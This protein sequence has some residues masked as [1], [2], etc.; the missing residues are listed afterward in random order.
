M[1]QCTLGTP[2]FMPPEACRGDPFSARG[3][4]LWACGV[5]L[6]TL[7]CGRVPFQGKTVFATYNAIMDQE[8]AFPEGTSLS[9][10]AKS[11][12]RGML[13]KDPAARLSMEQVCNHD[14]VTGRGRL[15][16]MISARLLKPVEVSPEEVDSALSAY[17]PLVADGLTGVGFEEREYAPGSYLFRE[18]E[19]GNEMFYI[20]EGNVDIVVGAGRR[21]SEASVDSLEDEL[22]WE[23]AEVEVEDPQARRQRGLVGGCES[24]PMV[25]VR[26]ASGQPTCRTPAF[27]AACR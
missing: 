12:L 7:L 24:A 27:S 5:A 17:R 11:L 13:A 18:G 26:R 10:Q 2:A 9:E 19:E 16:R 25:V 20:V 4:D 6:Y 22:E 21:V 23:E 14:W 8:L 3:A 15:E 1:L